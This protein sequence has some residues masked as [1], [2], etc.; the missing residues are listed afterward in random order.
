VPYPPTPSHALASGADS[1]VEMWVNDT[2]QATSQALSHDY[3]DL[4][5][6]P[7]TGSVDIP[8]YSAVVLIRE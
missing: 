1:N 2:G 4:D 7:V 5:Q 6:N 8:A 3:V